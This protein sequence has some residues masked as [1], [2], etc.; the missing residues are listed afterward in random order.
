[1]SNGKVMIIS[2]G[3][4][5]LGKYAVKY[6]LHNGWKVAFFSRE[7]STFTQKLIL[8]SDL[9]DKF[10]W[11]P[12][13]ILDEKKVT[14]FCRNV[15]KHFKRIDALINNA[16]VG[17][18]G[19]LTLTSSNDI[20]QLIDV[21]FK[22]VV[23][24]TKACLKYFLVNK[25]G[26]IV[27]I[28]SINSI[29]GHEGLSVYAGTKAALSG[30]TIALAK[31]V[32]VRNIRVN[33]IAPGYLDTDMTKSFTDKQRQRIIRR[34]PLGRLGVVEDI[35]GAI[36]FILSDSAKFITGQTLVVDGGLTC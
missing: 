23:N 21:N 10:Y 6:F 33:S 16:G 22:S 27:N 8:D 7:K 19:I 2:G 13:D 24:L 1:M 11:E 34:T 36:E 29:R 14:Q 15:Y 26:S 31:E 32:G 20:N 35:I 30:F 4:R 25:S 12:L 3:S 18:D 17:T 9:K 28:S 5:G